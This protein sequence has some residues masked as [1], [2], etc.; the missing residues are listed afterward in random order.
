M[1]SLVRRLSTWR[2]PR[3]L[4]VRA[5][6]TV[7]CRSIPAAGARAQQQ[8]SHTPL[9]C[10]SI[11][12]TDRR[13]SD[14][15]IDSDPYTMRAA[16]IIIVSRKWWAKQD[17]DKCWD[18]TYRLSSGPSS[19]RLIKGREMLTVVARRLTRSSAIAEGPR[20]ASCQLK[21]DTIRDA[22]LTCARKPT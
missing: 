13:T 7:S 3:L 9:L 2:Y 6:R 10:Q 4:L 20:D 15:Y 18:Q 21:Y 19:C 12:G 17:P 1:L 5:L 22:I 16:S 14:R 8:T 11:D